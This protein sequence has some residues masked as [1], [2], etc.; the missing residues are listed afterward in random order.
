MVHSQSWRIKS[1]KER[2][3]RERRGGKGNGRSKNIKKKYSPQTSRNI[4]K[5]KK[6]RREQSDSTREA[7]EGGAKGGSIDGTVLLGTT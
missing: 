1:R 3:P 5:K 6:K 7:R 2:V 4:S